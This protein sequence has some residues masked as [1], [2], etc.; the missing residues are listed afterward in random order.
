MSVAEVAPGTWRLGSMIGPRNLYQ[1][2]IADGGQ[3]LVVDTGMTATPREVIMPALRAVGIAAGEVSMVVVTHPD[4]D[5]QGGLA[6]LREVLPAA[7]AACG[8]ADRMMVSE[9]E[10]LVTDRYGAYELEHDLGY[11]PADKVWMRANYGA[12]ALVEI[13]FAGGEAVQV[14]A[15]RLV[16]HHAPGHS[17]GHLVLHEPAAGLL[18]TSDAVHWRMCPAADGSPALPPTY[19]DVDAYLETIGMIASLDAREVHSGHWPTCTGSQITEFLDES[20]AFVD[21]MDEA[22]AERLDATATLAQLCNHAEERLGPFGAD[23]IN[24]MFAVHGHL[25]R[26]LRTGRA[27][28]VRAGERPPRYRRS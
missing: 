27:Q 13:G 2:L 18:F 12:P 10:R 24:L 14:G 21:R 11:G 23:P 19:E 3:A 17:A 8:F 15:R 25:R 22:I 28:V 9:P 26:M 6:G 16:V 5:H 20:R 4:L 1:Y 7:A